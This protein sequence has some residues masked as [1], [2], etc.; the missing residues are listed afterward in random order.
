MN[1]PKSPKKPRLTV[2]ETKLIQGIAQGKPKRVAALEAGYG[3]T[4]ESASAI[5]TKTLAK[6][7]VQEA[8]HEAL[9]KHGITLDQAIAPIGKALTATKI[10]ISGQGDQAFAEVVE[11]IELQLKGSD[12]AL[13]LMG[14]SNPEGGTTNIN[15]INVAKDDKEEFNL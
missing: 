2:K 13:K 11:D 3:S 14:V 7:N 10:L 12:R 6:V 15:F 5:A 9:V 1:Q 8:L 4:I